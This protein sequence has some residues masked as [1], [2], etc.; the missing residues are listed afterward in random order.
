[1]LKVSFLQLNNA[2]SANRSALISIFNDFS[3]KNLSRFG[4]RFSNKLYQ[5]KVFNVKITKNGKCVGTVLFAPKRKISVKTV[6]C[7][8]LNRG[9]VRAFWKKSRKTDKKVRYATLRH[10]HD[11]RINSESPLYIFLKNTYSREFINY[12]NF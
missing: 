2:V 4:S 7:K 9:R 1:M 11:R 5:N 10:G 3:Y 8:H 6:K 12:R